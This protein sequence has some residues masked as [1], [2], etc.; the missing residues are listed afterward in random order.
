[1]K[2]PFVDFTLQKSYKKEIMSDIESIIDKGDFVY[3]DRITQLEKKV[4]DY[5]GVSKCVMVSSGTDA[6]EVAL[7][8]LEIKPYHK[9]IVP[10][11]SFIASAAAISLTGG[12]PYFVDV[13]PDTW[14]IDVD[15]VIDIIDSDSK[16]FAVI[17]VH[18]Y[19]LPVPNLDKL[20]SYCKSK[21]VY[22]LE[23]VA[24]AFGAKDVNGNY[25]GTRSSISAFSFYP[26]KNLGTF[27]HGG[28]IASNY[29]AYYNNASIMKNH[30]EYKKYYSSV[31]G[32]NASMSTFQAVVLNRL[33]DL[34]DMM[35][36]ARKAAAADYYTRI[37]ISSILKDKIKLQEYSTTNV[38]HLFVIK[39]PKEDR[40]LLVSY[41]RDN[42]IGC[43]IHYPV[44]I[45][46]QQA[47]FEFNNLELPVVEDLADSILSLPMFAG[48]SSEQINYVCSKLEDYFKNKVFN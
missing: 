26:T 38:Y 35:N 2:V 27:G 15:K 41:L 30:G 16:I 39:V 19:G 18:L 4:E 40:D 11:N 3:S 31:V 10:S 42:G 34:I 37:N 6:L 28:M 23:D 24:Q 9:V 8:A 47:F 43:A 21:G 44:P 48:I 13:N 7:R 22:V 14:V 12:I 32:T 1:M 25:V 17:P 20:I 36:F 33:I 46:K 5:L 29:P 45:H